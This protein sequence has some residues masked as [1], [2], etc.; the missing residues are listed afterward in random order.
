VRV[1]LV[2]SGDDYQSASEDLMIASCC[3]LY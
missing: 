3:M 2:P 1:I